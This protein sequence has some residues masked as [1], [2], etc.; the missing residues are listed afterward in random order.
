MCYRE[1]VT[2]LSFKGIHIAC[3]CG[4]NGNGKSAIFDA[5]TW[6][7]WGESRAKSDDDLIHLGQSETDI[8]LEFLARKQLYRVI[9]KRVR[10][11]GKSRAGQT[12]LE[13]QLA[14]N[15]TFKSISGNTLQ[16]T[17]Q[18]II[19]I[20]RLDYQTFKNS[21]FL[22]Q[23]HADEFSIKR[24]GERKEILAN[25]LSLSLYDDFERK[26]KDLASMRSNDTGNLITS[27]ADI[28]SQLA[29]KDGYNA[30][31]EKFQDEL[32]KLEEH[33]KDKESNLSQLRLK[34]ESLKF[35]EEQLSETETQ[36]NETTKALEY[37]QNK[38]TE[39]KANI[40]EYEKVLS[41]TEAI[42]KGYSEFVNLSR[43]NEEMNK[44]LRDLLALRERAGN[45]EKTIREQTQALTIEHE[46]IQ[47]RITEKETKLGN[48]QKLEADLIQARSNLSNSAKLEEELVNSRNHVQQLASEISY[49]KSSSV[50]LQDGI[51][52]LNEKIGLLTGGET[53]C[54]LCE[55]DLGVD[56]LHLIET[57]YNA[58]LGQKRKTRQDI[59]EDLNNKIAELQQTEALLVKEEATVHKERAERQ[60]ILSLIEKDLTDTRKAGEDLVV[61]KEKLAEIEQQLT[62][63]D[64]AIEEQQALTLAEQ[65]E[66]L[67]GYDKEQHNMMQQ[68]LTELDKYVQLNQKLDEAGKAIVKEKLALT[69]AEDTIS[70]NKNKKDICLK[71]REDINGEIAQMADIPTKLTEAETEFQTIIN[72]E[73]Q[74]RDNLATVQERIRH[75]TELEKSKQEKEKLYDQLTREES[76]YQEL[77]EVFSKK[78]IQ[79]MLIRQALPEIE[80]EANRLLG[81]MTD[82]RLS[83][84][85]ESQREL[86]SKKGDIVETLD[87]KIADELGTRNY[88]MYSG[89]EAFRIDLA[90]RIALSKLLVRRAGASLPLLII[91]EG[92]GTQDSTGRE[93]L[94]D[95]INSIQDDFEKIFVI[96]HLEELKE[97]FPV[98]INVTKT[99]SGSVI[100]VS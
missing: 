34:N 17:Q 86:K 67:L 84:T 80:I 72:S 95:A 69:E 8:E 91:D 9:R 56:K 98:L 12:V 94:V 68:Q 15:D 28:N 60:S 21:A 50:Q 70:N 87:I 97:S 13:L 37:W 48:I 29:Q 5:L 61:E 71:K 39:H 25:I 93:R 22:R 40:D 73:R 33:K 30:E 53:H 99:S 32:N 49:L 81:K 57:K 75:L 66:K 51:S 16:E 1:N 26:A 82:N 55:T 2:P 27:I 4:D 19:D 88:E 44:K 83:L 78:G 20:L 31:L 90:L 77:A 65:E 36:I 38:C 43:L 62:G 58:E 45:L 24:P 64:Y 18:K 23:G 11:S 41:E 76:I 100:T 46:K 74:L 42:Q 10:G 96:T 52:G 47:V 7:L 54:P 79:A 89:G 14:N 59:D 92:F 3:L 85:L 63:K 35:K 6:A